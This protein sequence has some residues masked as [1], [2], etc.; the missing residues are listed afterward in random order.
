MPE[1]AP[2]ASRSSESERNE[3]RQTLKESLKLTTFL[4]VEA[5]AVDA[6]LPIVEAPPCWAHGSGGRSSEEVAANAGAEI[7]LKTM[8]S[9]SD[10]ASCS[11]GSKNLPLI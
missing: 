9:I 10:P 4:D 2:K 1:D 8:E 3:K 6:L 5:I 11:Q 7:V